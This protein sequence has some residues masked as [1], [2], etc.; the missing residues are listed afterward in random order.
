MGLGIYQKQ[1]AKS[2]FYCMEQAAALFQS[3]SESSS[4]DSGSKSF[5]P[6]VFY[7]ALSVFCRRD[8]FCKKK[9]PGI[10]ALTFPPVSFAFCGSLP[11][12]TPVPLPVFCSGSSDFCCLR[13]GQT[14]RKNS[15]ILPEKGIKKRPS[16]EKGEGL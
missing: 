16:P 2:L 15:S 12:G 11:C 4:N 9:Y 7:S 13:A 8:L 3:G 6:A 14:C 10:T 1:S 5:D